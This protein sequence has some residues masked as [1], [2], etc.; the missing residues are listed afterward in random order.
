MTFVSRTISI[1]IL[2]AAG[3]AV[4]WAIFERL[5]EL[6]KTE[7]AAGANAARAPV[8]VETGPVERG[9]ITLRRTFSG[10][11]VAS[12]EFVVAPKI[13]GRLERLEADLGDT[14]RR[15]QVVALLDDDVLVQAVLQAEADL[16]VAQA[17]LE[18]AGSALEI[19]VR[20]L[21]RAEKLSEQRV[22]SEASLD[23]AKADELAARAHVTVTK[24]VV[25]RAEASLE[26]A[27]IRRGYAQVTADWNEGD[28]ERLVAERLV[29]EGGTVS[30]NAALL[31]I[32]DL[33]PIVGVVNVPER[34][35]ARLAE[36]QLASL[37]TDSYPGR[38][39]EGRVTRIAPVFRSSTRQ[40]RVE[41]IVENPDTNLRPGMFVRATLELERVADATIVPFEA[42]T[43][44]AGVTGVF[45]LDAAGETVAWR[46][47]EVGVR[48]E[49]RVAVRGEGLSGRVVILG[50]ELCDDGSRVTVADR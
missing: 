40:A 38:T 45:L 49:G 23:A 1:L 29:D 50:Q 17:S 34:D 28:E 27:R 33:D 16:A 9:S 24:A 31:S 39:F 35:Y 37:T 32:V 44:H 21:Q 36:G 43:E 7:A 3:T 20:A 10:T 47:V 4:A 13:G 46:P 18:E 2:L 48:E 6:E 14:V 41:M 12:A 19:A 11:L 26:T 5:S 15:G 25:T 22:T 42:L 8:P 30:A